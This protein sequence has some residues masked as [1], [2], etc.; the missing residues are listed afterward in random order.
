MY[1]VLN[2]TVRRYFWRHSAKFPP[3]QICDVIYRK[4]HLHYK[5][6]GRHARVFFGLQSEN[7]RGWCRS[8]IIVSDAGGGTA[9]ITAVVLLAAALVEERGDGVR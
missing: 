4:H 1:L 2:K 6:R 8:K 5:M 7:E 3:L 9:A